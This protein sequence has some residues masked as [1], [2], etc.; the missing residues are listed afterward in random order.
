MLYFNARTILRNEIPGH[1]APEK[2]N[3]SITRL[4]EKNEGLIACKGIPEK[5]HRFAEELGN[6]TF[7]EA[8]TTML[9]TDTIL[10]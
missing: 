7:E 10:A 3:E 1:D 4:L 9:L 2:A 6:K 8:K 5:I